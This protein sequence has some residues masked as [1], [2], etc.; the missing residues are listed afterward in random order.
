MTNRFALLI[1]NSSFDYYTQFP[2]LS[3]PIQDVKELAA[4]LKDPKIGNFQVSTLFDATYQTI[5]R[6]WTHFCTIR[7]I[8]RR[9]INILFGS[10]EIIEQGRCF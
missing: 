9:F 10:W 3:S 7:K 4:V 5:K 2:A 8:K 6:L 1:G